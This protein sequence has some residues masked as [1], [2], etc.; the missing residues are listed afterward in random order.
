M[1]PAR[2]KALEVVGVVLG[3]AVIVAIAVLVAIFVL[4]VL[5]FLAIAVPLSSVASQK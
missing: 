2:V 4:Y 3:S 1:S 5:F